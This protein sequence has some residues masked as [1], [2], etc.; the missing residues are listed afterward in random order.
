MN[1]EMK[2]SE[3]P[4]SKYFFPPAPSTAASQERRAVQKAINEISP[5]SAEHGIGL[6]HL[7]WLF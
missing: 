4:L 5:P 3:I 1:V 2:K 6:K 7:L